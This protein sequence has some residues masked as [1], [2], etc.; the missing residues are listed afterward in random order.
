MSGCWG[1]EEER[2]NSDAWWKVVVKEGRTRDIGK[3]FWEM[4]TLNPNSEGEQELVCEERHLGKE[5]SAGCLW[6]FQW[7]A[8][9]VITDIWKHPSSF[10]WT[11]V[12]WNVSTKQSW[13]SSYVFYCWTFL[14]LWNMAYPEKCVRHIKLTSNF[15][16]N[17]HVTTTNSALSASERCHLVPSPAPCY[18]TCLLFYMGP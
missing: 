18:P 11:Q 1:K 12:F 17:T 5:T 8:T 10:K 16:V 14:K 3:D 13:T 2:P 9:R 7:F 4:I 15:K 6:S